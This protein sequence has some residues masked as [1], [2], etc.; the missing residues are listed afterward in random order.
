MHA[1]DRAGE[2]IRHMVGDGQVRKHMDISGR[3]VLIV[4][5]TTGIGRVL[6]QRFVDAGS[7]VVVGGRNI[8]Q[9][10]GVETV[11][12]DVTDAASVAQARD[13]VL[14]KH[15]ELDVVVTMSGVMLTED[16]RDP[17]HIAQAETTISVSDTRRVEGGRALVHRIAA[18]TS[19]ALVSL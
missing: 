3:T 15:P 12:I 7:T 8:E 2:T 19:L 9:V 1:G 14:A 10:D 5:G 17:D 4:G 13:E 11:R 18:R 16:L 6:A